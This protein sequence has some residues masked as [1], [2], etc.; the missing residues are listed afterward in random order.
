VQAYYFILA[1]SISELFENF[2]INITNDCIYIGM[3]PSNGN[4]PHSYRIYISSRE[5]I[6]LITT[7]DLPMQITSDSLLN[8]P[9]CSDT[10]LT[11]LSALYPN[12]FSP[13]ELESPSPFDAE[14]TEI[15]EQR[16][17]YPELELSCT[18]RSGISVSSMFSTAMTPAFNTETVVSPHSSVTDI[19][20]NNDSSRD[21]NTPPPTLRRNSF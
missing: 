6:L 16:T 9:N 19:N 12:V 21:Y 14:I 17:N 18:S 5:G 20:D 3:L 8:D 1:N 13:N 2:T 15:V 7:L 4:G 11:I 10:I